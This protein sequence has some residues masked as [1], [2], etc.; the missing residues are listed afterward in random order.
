M[1]LT[2]SPSID[3]L[4]IY[5]YDYPTEIIRAVKKTIACNPIEID[6]EIYLDFDEDNRLIGIEIQNAKNKIDKGIIDVADILDK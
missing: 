1:K 4:Y 6:G 5:L 2:Y 3:A